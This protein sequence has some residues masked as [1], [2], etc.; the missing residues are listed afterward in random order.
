MWLEGITDRFRERV[1]RF[2]GRIARS[3]GYFMLSIQ[4]Q[5]LLSVDRNGNTITNGEENRENRQ[6]IHRAPLSHSEGR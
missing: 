3:F 6:K 4:L 2:I 5:K 1:T